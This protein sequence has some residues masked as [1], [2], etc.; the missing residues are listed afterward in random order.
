MIIAYVPWCSVGIDFG[1]VS[2]QM[3]VNYNSGMYRLLY[4]A[5]YVGVWNQAHFSLTIPTL[6]ET[7]I[8]V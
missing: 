7:S 8:N 2:A 6:A 4:E 1:K 5:I 3:R